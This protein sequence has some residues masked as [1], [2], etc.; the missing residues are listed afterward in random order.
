MRAGRREA[1]ITFQRAT[2]TQDDYGEEALSWAS[3]GTEWAA[4]F[5]G[6][7]DERRQAAME[8]G[9]QSATF[10]VLSNTVTRSVTLKDRLTL[11]GYIWDIVSIAPM[12]RGL[13]EFTGTATGEADATSP[14]PNDVGQLDFSEATNSGL[15]ALLGDDWGLV[16]SS[17]D[18]GQ[19]DF[20]EPAN[21]GLVTVLWEA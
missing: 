6:R 13:I 10:Q 5:Y 1:L 17:E 12:Q 9:Q 18:G 2:A 14:L 21:S 16:T 4:V 7:G 11:G 20:S 15:L 3:L 19:M 8:Q